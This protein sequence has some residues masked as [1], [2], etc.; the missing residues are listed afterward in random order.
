MLSTV[1]AFKKKGE[2]FQK[3]LLLKGNAFKHQHF[4]KLTVPAFLKDNFQN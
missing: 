3:L 2:I 1:I 4:R